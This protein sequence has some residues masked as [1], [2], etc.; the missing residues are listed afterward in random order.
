MDGSGDGDGD[1]DGDE[2]KR[3]VMMMIIL[4]ESVM[5]DNTLHEQC[6]LNCS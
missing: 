5:I 1:G 2:L 6:L 3:I 4:Y